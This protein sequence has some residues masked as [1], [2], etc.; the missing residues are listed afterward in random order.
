M[1]AGGRRSER[2]LLDSA[3]LVPVALLL[4]LPT[5]W[6]AG[7]VLPGVITPRAGPTSPPSRERGTDA[8]AVPSS[9]SEV[10]QLSWS[11]V[12]FDEQRLPWLDAQYS[13]DLSDGGVIQFGGSN[14]EANE[15]VNYTY[16][17]TKGGNWVNVSPIDSP[18][19][20]IG[21]A[22]A[23]STSEGSVVLFGGEGP[24]VTAN[25]SIP[26][27]VYD[28]VWTYQNGSWTNVTPT[29]GPAPPPTVGATFADDPADSGM[30]LFGGLAE[31]AGVGVEASNQT[32]LWSGTSWKEETTS[33]APSPRYYASMALDPGTEQ[34]VLFGGEVLNPT[35][36]VVSLNDTWVYRSGTWTN[37]T[38]AFAPPP[39]YGGFD[40]AYD[41]G[42][43]SL[44]T[45]ARYNASQLS[46]TTWA[47][48]NGSWRILPVDGVLPPPGVATLVTDSYANE[49]LALP[50]PLDS[51]SSVLSVEALDGMTWTVAESVNF[52][53]PAPR[54]QASASYDAGTESLVEFGGENASGRLGDTNEFGP[55]GVAVPI[56]GPLSPSAREGAGFAWDGTTQSALLFGGDGS[57]PL[58]D[59]WIY[60]SDET[61]SEL[62]GGRAP[63]PEAYGCLAS[64]PLNGGVLYFGGISSSG[65]LLGATW[66]WNASQWNELAPVDAPARRAFAACAWDPAANGVLLVGGASGFS[67]DLPTGPYF[68]DTWLFNGT[69]WR[70]LGDAGL[71]GKP[72]ADGLLLQLDNASD[73]PLALLPGWNGSGITE[74]TWFL[75]ASDDWVNDTGV[76]GSPYPLV[77][78]AG[79]YLP[80]LGYSEVVSGGTGIVDGELEYIVTEDDALDD[81]T[82]APTLSALPTS[83]DAAAYSASIGT[84]LAPYRYLWRF[85]DGTTSV[86]ASGTHDYPGSGTY[87]GSL[88]LVDTLG[89]EI[90]A[91]F[92]VTVTGPPRP[93]AIDLAG[94]VVSPTSGAAPLTV[95]FRGNATGGLPPYAYVWTFGDGGSN[96]SADSSHTYAT[97]GTFEVVLKVTG[98]RGS[99][100]ARFWN[101]TVNA[102]SG[103]GS[104]PIGLGGAAGAIWWYAAVGIAVA[105]A[106]L[107]VLIYVRR[108]PP[109]ATETTS[110]EGSMSPGGGAAWTD[111]DGSA[112]DPTG[113]P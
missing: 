113:E 19:P 45:F 78:A 6:A 49:A 71:A 44:V 85:G 60:S 79:S 105:A 35:G 92:Q 99:T 96:R 14:G 69:N 100:G 39:G 53:L 109:P 91:A 3:L 25:C 18:P 12:T 5:S 16:E 54:V 81:L 97:T 21:A 38:S 103:T 50:N 74:G 33:N 41:A 17:F 83:E 72:S 77:G 66:I 62:G 86:N 11:S 90:D 61:W 43:T 111:V 48:D 29:T 87:N 108:S 8:R 110:E 98:G 42:A 47:Y 63:P 31:V 102:E 4:L 59:T 89:T 68:S 84:G 2:L 7:G 57:T 9:A 93:T 112:P 36:G 58:N 13:D 101:V 82:A 20:R 56:T 80:A 37:V 51:D 23:Y 88:T 76:Q 95:T 30:L 46:G 22:M 73:S 10:S 104:S 70:E 106:A 32:W 24:C 26:G 107:A 64:D 40:L 94:T 34:D 75:N 1:R 28:D 67:D 55:D 65:G 27:P 15:L 52:S